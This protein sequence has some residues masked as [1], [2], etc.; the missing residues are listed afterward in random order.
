ML[1][2]SFLVSVLIA[3][4]G[5]QLASSLTCYTCLNANDCKK[6]KT[7]TCTHA[8]AN[9]T[10]YYLGVY[11]QNVHWVPMNRYDCLALKYTYR[12]NNT[13]THQLHGCVHP[14]VNVCNLSLKPEYSS[15][16]RAHCNVCSGNKCNKS[17]AGTLSRSHYTIVA[18]VL[19]L[20]LAKIYA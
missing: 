20:V 19:A 8:A 16:R 15:W 6:A 7:T 17:P 13:V 2:K 3:I 11:H 10:S 5:V 4:T 9:E 14:D 12:N 1:T 18:A